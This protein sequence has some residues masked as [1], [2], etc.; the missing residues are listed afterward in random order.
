[1][2]KRPEELAS[3]TFRR[4]TSCGVA[5]V[6]ITEEDGVGREMFAHMGKSGTCARA[7]LEALSRTVSIAMEHG[8]PIEQLVKS[9]NGI[10]CGSATDEAPSCVTQIARVMDKYVRKEE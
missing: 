5:Y 4:K 9:L 6:T 3:K 7:I 1:M 8:A 2:T 10:N